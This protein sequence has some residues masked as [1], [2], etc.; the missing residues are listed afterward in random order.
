MVTSRPT[1]APS[2]TS[3]KRSLGM[4][5]A[6][7]MSV[8]AG[9]VAGIP[10]TRATSES[11]SWPLNRTPTCVLVLMDRWTSTCG[12]AGNGISPRSAAAL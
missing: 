12:V 2:N 1:I 9:R 4:V 11:G 5:A 10:S 7:S 6:S 8:R 3:S